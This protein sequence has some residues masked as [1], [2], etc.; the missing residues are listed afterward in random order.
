[1]TGI[2]GGRAGR[3]AAR[4]SDPRCHPICIVDASR[5][6]A[7]NTCGA[8]PIGRSGTFESTLPTIWPSAVWLIL[9]RVWPGWR[10]AGGRSAGHRRQ[11]APSWV[12]SPLVAP[13][14]TSWTTT[15]WFV[16]SR[17]HWAPGRWESA[18]GRTANS[19]RTAQARTPR[20]RAHSVAL[21]AR[22]AEQ[23]VTD[24]AHI[25]CESPWPV[26]M[27]HPNAVTGRVGWWPRRR[28]S[29]YVSPTFVR[30][31]ACVEPMRAI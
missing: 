9:R 20:L 13:L 16:V 23:T 7:R 25:C 30:S 4:H 29:Q 12:R 2:I 18:L 6:P 3:G 28:V 22:T 17:S 10:G 11:M 27:Q 8:T 19:R 15:H 26:R 21:H 31:A 1:M 24:L 14:A 5:P